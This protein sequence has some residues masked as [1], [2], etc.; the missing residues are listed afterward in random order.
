[1]ITGVP[2]VSCVPCRAPARAPSMVLGFL[3]NL[4]QGE[5]GIELN[6]TRVQ[7]SINRPLL[8]RDSIWPKVLINTELNSVK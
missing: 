1:M 4:K 7:A 2:C 6:Q 8:F 3:S 5:K